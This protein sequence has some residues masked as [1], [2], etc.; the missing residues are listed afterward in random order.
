MTLTGFHGH[1]Q[2]AVHDA[3]QQPPAGELQVAQ[4][5]WHRLQLQ[6]QA[7]PLVRLQVQTQ[8]VEC[9]CQEVSWKTGHQTMTA[10]LVQQVTE[11]VG[12]GPQCGRKHERKEETEG[13]DKMG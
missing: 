9:L 10:S 13:P 1:L 3:G 12:R 2:Q 6:E 4:H 5:H 8:R 11:M 7:L